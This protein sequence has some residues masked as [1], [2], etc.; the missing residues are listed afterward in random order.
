M[1]SAIANP[2]PVAAAAPGW[3]F[4][5]VSLAIVVI[6]LEI[7]H[8][9]RLGLVRQ[10]VR[11]IAIIV[12]YSCGFFAARATV[13]LMRSYFRLPDPILALLGGAILGAILFAAINLAG[14]F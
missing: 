13:P 4:V 2:Q 6:L 1:L 10:L 7:V 3:Q 12:A 14:A 8:G 9:W 5:F 11:V